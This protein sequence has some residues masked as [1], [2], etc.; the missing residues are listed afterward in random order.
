MKRQK[1]LNVKGGDFSPRNEML[2]TS[3]GSEESF[4]KERI[5]LRKRLKGEAIKREILL[6][7][8]NIRTI[9]PLITPSKP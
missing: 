7:K 6:S 1:H 2:D 8:K 9:F 4:T 5:K 3:S